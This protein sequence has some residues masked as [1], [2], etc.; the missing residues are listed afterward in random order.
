MRSGKR[1]S[2][3]QAAGGGRRP[4]NEGREECFI[5]LGDPADTSEA[6]KEIRGASD[7]SS[8]KQQ[9]VESC[10]IAAAKQSLKT[11]RF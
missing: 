11:R 9:Q 4:E 1:R 3:R 2:E 7:P 8:N 5:I 10:R 6:T